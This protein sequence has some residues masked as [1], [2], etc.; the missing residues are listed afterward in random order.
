MCVCVCLKAIKIIFDDGTFFF[1]YDI[2][3][4]TIEMNLMMYKNR[5]SLK[6]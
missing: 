2:L 5:L 3:I 1:I 4:A 6:M